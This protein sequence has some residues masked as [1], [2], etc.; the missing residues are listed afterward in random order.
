MSTL[1]KIKKAE[2]SAFSTTTIF[3]KKLVRAFNSF[4]RT[5]YSGGK[6]KFTVMLIPHSEKQIFNFQISVFALVG[7]ALIFGLVFTGFIFYTSIFSSTNANMLQNA[8]ALKST[9]ANLDAIRDETNQLLKSAK[10]FE[11]ALQATLGSANGSNDTANQDPK[12]GDLSS[13][14]DVKETERGTLK[15]ISELKRVSDYLDNAVDPIKEIGAILNSKSALL[16]EIPNVWPVKGGL[17]HI[18]FYYG[19][20]ENPFT[21][22][23]YQHTGLDISTYS[24]GDPIIATADGEIVLMEYQPGGYGNQIVIKHKHGFYTRYAHMQSFRAAKGQKVKQGQVIG[25]IGNTGVSTGPHLHYEVM[26]GT[27]LVNPLE[28]ISLR[29]SGSKN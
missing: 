17:G 6:Q 2:N 29:S 28:F 15:E 16:T 3:F 26:L 5:M 12:L 13:F 20:N 4:L 9:Q 27:G 21:G 10:N 1:K 8:N 19:Q 24:T 14:L 11:A 25:F 23:F 22:L 18:S 7:S